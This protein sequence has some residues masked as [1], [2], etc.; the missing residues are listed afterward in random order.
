VEEAK[1]LPGDAV[2]VGRL[3]AHQ[4]VTVAT[5]IGDADVVAKD[6]QDVWFFFVLAVPFI[7][8]PAL[9]FSVFIF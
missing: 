6:D 5:K 8:L 4:T 2:D 3:I 9:V 7:L 1:A